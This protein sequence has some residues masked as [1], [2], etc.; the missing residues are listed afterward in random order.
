M[1]RNTMLHIDV[2][3]AAPSGREGREPDSGLASDFSRC[4]VRV[5]HNQAWRIGPDW[6]R[7]PLCHRDLNFYQRALPA[8]SG[9][10][11]RE[12]TSGATRHRS[13]FRLV[14]WFDR[15]ALS[16]CRK[17]AYAPFAK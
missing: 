8:V 13:A 11:A 10:S 1:S 3:R 2:L 14:L 5:N 17:F 6:F 15:F 16:N 12:P 7:L 4:I 9:M